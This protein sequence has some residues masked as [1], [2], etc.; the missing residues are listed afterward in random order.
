ML[1]AV[2]SS[3]P[4]DAPAG[5]ACRLPMLAECFSLLT[6]L[7]TTVW[8]LFH[9]DTTNLIPVHHDIICR[10]CLNE[11]QK[12]GRQVLEEVAVE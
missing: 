4:Q 5:T 11:T 6:R 2:E 9:P 12:Q 8:Y 7:V 1:V 3:A 10:R